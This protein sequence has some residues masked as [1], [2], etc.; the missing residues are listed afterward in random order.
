MLC[1]KMLLP[2]VLLGASIQSGGGVGVMVGGWGEGEG[3]GSSA[4]PLMDALAP[5]AKV[6]GIDCA[7]LSA[8]ICSQPPHT[9]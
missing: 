5:S 4:A 3:E 6:N 2:L 1:L 8:L 9:Q 7:P